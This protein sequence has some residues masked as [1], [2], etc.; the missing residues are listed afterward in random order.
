MTAALRD[1]WLA[2]GPRRLAFVGKAMVAILMLG[3]LIG[4]VFFCCSC[5]R[6]YVHVCVYINICV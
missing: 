4:S 5:V 3:A 1:G 2:P 6:M